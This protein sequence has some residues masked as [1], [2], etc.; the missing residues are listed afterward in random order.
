MESRVLYPGG[1]RTLEL[2]PGGADVDDDVGDVAEDGGEEHEAEYELDDDEEELAF[3]ARL[4]DATGGRQCQSAEV[5][6]LQVL[7]DAVVG[8]RRSGPLPLPDERLVETVVAHDDAVETGVPVKDD[9]QVVDEADGAEHVRVVG[10][11]LRPVHERPEPVDL[12]EPEA[13][14][15]G[16]ESDGQVEKVEREEAKAV[17]VERRRVHVVLAQF[18]GV[19]L[20]HAFLQIARPEVE[21]NV[22]H[23][24]QIAKVVETQPHHQRVA[25]D[26]LEGKA[27]DEHPEVVEEGQRDHHRPIVA[28]TAGRVEHERPL[29][30]TSSR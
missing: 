16:V 28:Q 10:V 17:D 19:R 15:H 18:A 9:Q 24:D 29:A 12:D 27:V 8:V 25:G 6:A 2:L 13:A 3:C 22:Q 14:Q 7:S 4:E 11:P 20:Q 21:G 23:V 26:L 30:T 1:L 5:E